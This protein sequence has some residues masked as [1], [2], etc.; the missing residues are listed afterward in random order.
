MAFQFKDLM[1]TLSP[2][3]QV[4]MHL[5]CGPISVDTT[6]CPAASANEPRSKESGRS[7]EEIRLQLA[8]RQE[9]GEIHLN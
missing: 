3:V 2:S 1:F 8:E 9:R 5:T 6:Q 7:F 4:P